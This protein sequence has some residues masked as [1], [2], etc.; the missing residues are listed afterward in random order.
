[1][2]LP[3]SVVFF[4]T[5]VHV[6]VGVLREMRFQYAH[7]FAAITCSS[8]RSHAYLCVLVSAGRNCSETPQGGS[9][10]HWLDP[11]HRCQETKTV[12]VG[13]SNPYRLQAVTHERRGIWEAGPSSRWMVT[14]WLVGLGQA[15]GDS[16]ACRSCVGPRSVRA[17]RW[18]RG[19]DGTL[20]RGE[21]KNTHKS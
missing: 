8:L 16:G 20:L 15:L 19:A 12:T 7:R 13:E 10:G 14:G 17:S 21:P 1:M 11:S 6:E 3:V 4:Y 18:A 2:V 5:E 9:K